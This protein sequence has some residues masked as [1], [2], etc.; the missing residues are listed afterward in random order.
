MMRIRTAWRRTYAGA[1][2]GRSRAYTPPFLPVPPK[3]RPRP[4]FQMNFVLAPRVQDRDDAAPQREHAAR[5][6]EAPVQQPHRGRREH[7]EEVSGRAR[8]SA[9]LAGYRRYRRLCLAHLPYFWRAPCLPRLLLLLLLLPPRQGTAVPSPRGGLASTAPR[10]CTPT[11]T[12]TAQRPAASGGRWDRRATAPLF[13]LRPSPPVSPRAASRPPPPLS[14]RPPPPLAARSLASNGAPALPETRPSTKTSRRTLGARQR[15]SGLRTRRSGGARTTAS[16]RTTTPG[17]STS[18]RSPRSS[19]WI[20]PAGP[21]AAE[22]R[23]GAREEE[24][25]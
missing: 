17:A 9:S 21:A 1:C 23:W 4:C 14:L 24:V 19:T 25:A 11:A 22:P 20:S 6:K 16:A 7:C 13:V 3:S 12:P 2:Q 5:G 8:P 15:R 10:T 18:T